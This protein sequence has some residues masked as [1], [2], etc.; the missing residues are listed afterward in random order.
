MMSFLEKKQLSY[1]IAARFHQGV[2]RAVA[3]GRWL[4]LK[5]GVEV[6]ECQHAFSQ[7]GKPRRLIVVRKEIAKDMLNRSSRMRIGVSFVGWV[8]L[9]KRQYQSDIDALRGSGRP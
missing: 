7:K 9:S 8:S 6:M 3:E 5:D 2:K 4:R 1:I